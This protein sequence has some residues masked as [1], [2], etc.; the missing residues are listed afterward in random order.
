MVSIGFIQRPQLEESPG[1][2][3]VVGLPP[4]RVSRCFA[5]SY[6]AMRVVPIKYLSSL[7][8][9]AINLEY[10]SPSWCPTLNN[11]TNKIDKNGLR[12][13]AQP[14][15]DTWRPARPGSGLLSLSIY[16]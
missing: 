8:K 14:A 1:G 10:Q 2:K 9:D 5:Q 7:F 3:H 13:S 15:L 16:V 12:A 11:L 4:A 6:L